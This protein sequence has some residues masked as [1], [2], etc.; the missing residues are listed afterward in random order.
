MFDV[1]KPEHKHIVVIRTAT[2][3]E[4]SNYEKRTLNK[5]K[6]VDLTTLENKIE[7]VKVN[8]ERIEV[9][10]L[11]REVQ[12]NLGALSKKDEIT[13]KELSADELFWIKCEL[14]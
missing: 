9:D 7:V 11:N 2:G 1:H 10:P 5:L 13:P 8:G 4:L 12:I 14:D 3:N 6:D